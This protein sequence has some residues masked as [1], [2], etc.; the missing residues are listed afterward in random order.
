MKLDY[1]ITDVFTKQLFNGAQIAVFPK[2]DALNAEKMQ[3]IARELNLSE[4]VFIFHRANNN[5]VRRMRIF[6]PFGEIDFAGHPI[7]GA[8]YV[9]ASSGD[10][11]LSNPITSV[12]FEQNAGPVEAN[13]TSAGGKPTFVQFSRMVTP[14]VD[15]FALYR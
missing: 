6:S 8:A 14:I 1:Y 3:L 5:P 10:I 7:I 12:C 13:I 15:R 2:A 9:L 4:T 11:A